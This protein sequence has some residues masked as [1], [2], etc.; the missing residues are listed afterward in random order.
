MEELAA[1]EPEAF[2]VWPDNM[3]VIDAFLAIATQWRTVSL[4]E[5]RVHWIGLDYAAARAAFEMAGVT[6]APPVWLG[7]RVMEREAAAALNGVLG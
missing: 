1:A 6:V 2:D 5:G 7:V 3:P 4:A